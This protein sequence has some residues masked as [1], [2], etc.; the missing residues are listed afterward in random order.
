MSQLASKY[1]VFTNFADLISEKKVSFEYGND[2]FFRDMEKKIKAKTQQ[3]H[4]KVKNYQE[5]PDE[6]PIPDF[7]ESLEISFLYLFDGDSKNAMKYLIYAK[8]LQEERD[9]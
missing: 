1:P 2:S 7:E 4:E 3:F 9:F 5:Y 8:K 6:F